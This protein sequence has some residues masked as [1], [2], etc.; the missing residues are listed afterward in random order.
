MTAKL[1][2]LRVLIVDDNAHML[3]IVKTIL[4]G[5]G[6]KQFYEARSVNEAFETSLTLR[7]S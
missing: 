2:V 5:F 3:Q 6:I 1:D 7:A 4:R